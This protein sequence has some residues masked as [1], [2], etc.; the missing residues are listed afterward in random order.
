ML[1]S[2]TLIAKIVVALV[3][4]L[5]DEIWKLT[6]SKRQQSCRYL[7]KLYYAVQSLEEVTGRVV[8]STERNSENGPAAALIRV[9]IEE[10]DAIEFSSN[11]FVDLARELQR[12]LALLDPPLHQL[13]RSI[14]RGKA[15]FLRYM[16]FGLRPDF[17][18]GGAQVVLCIPNER[19]LSTDFESAY[20][21]S[22][23]VV[24]A[25][26]EYYW[27]AGAFEYIHDC[28]E[29]E[30]SSESNE[31]AKRVTSFLR[32]HHASLV[33]ASERLR[34]LLKESFTIEELL[35]HKDETPT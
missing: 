2:E 13:C 33:T 6:T 16:S 22:C 29:V 18:G 1:T 34:V 3:G 31:A 23:Q 21:Q 32:S 8:S 14:Y 7:V 10:Q 24:A 26:N 9:L 4:R 5:S 35:F 30:I 27:P 20:T 19:L 12:G 25:G 11:A 15:D 28:D 17:S